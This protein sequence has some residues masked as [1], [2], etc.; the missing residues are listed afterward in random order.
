MDKCP[1]IEC[2]NHEDCAII[3][4]T[5]KVPMFKERCSYFKKGAKDKE[6]KPKKKEETDGILST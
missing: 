3:A 5:K 4:I 6:N 2:R 1:H